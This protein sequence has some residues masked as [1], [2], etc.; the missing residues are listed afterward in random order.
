MKIP[1]HDFGGN[2]NGRFLHFAHPNA[3]TPAC[4]QQLIKPLLPYYHVRRGAYCSMLCRACL[5]PLLGKLTF[6][7]V[8]VVRQASFVEFARPRAN[9]LH[10][11]MQTPPIGKPCLLND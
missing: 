3:Y 8:L 6:E 1:H 2:S 9:R 4:F 11:E 10:L 7:L 5:N